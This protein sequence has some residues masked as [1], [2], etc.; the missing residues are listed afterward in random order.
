MSRVLSSVATDGSVPTSAV[1]DVPTLTF[2]PPAGNANTP[3]GNTLHAEVVWP[4]GGAPLLSDLVATFAHLDLCVATHDLARGDLDSASVHRF[5]FRTAALEW[6][7]ATEALVSEAFVAATTGAVEVDGYLRLVATA[8]LPWREAVVVRA[9]ARY[10]R[11]CGLELSST[12]VIDLLAARPEYVRA[13]VALFR[14]RLDPRL[15][16]RDAA[17]AGAESSLTAAVAATATLDEDRLLRGL[18]S[19][20]SATLRTNW[21]R[22]HVQAGA[23]IAL[24]LDPSRV[25][26]PAT[27]RPAP[28]DLRPLRRCRGKPRPRWTDLARWAALVGSPR[29]LPDRGPRPDAHAGGEELADRADRGQGR[30]RGSRYDRTG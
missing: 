18:W 23:P 3:D 25:S 22:P 24:K 28:G 11:Q 7:A 4:Q 8:G 30:V 14:A 26:L 21:F 15:E 20:V 12:S 16:D 29:R 13:L 2:S 17:V 27:V 6:D 10:A 5:T 1:L 19:V 9:L